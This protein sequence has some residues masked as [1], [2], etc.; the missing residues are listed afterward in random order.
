MS[1]HKGNIVSGILEVRVGSACEY[2]LD[3]APFRKG[4]HQRQAGSAGSSRR[5]APTVSTVKGR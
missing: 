1:E 2:V 5:P 3:A 4:R